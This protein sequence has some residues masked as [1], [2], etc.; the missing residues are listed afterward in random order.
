MQVVR[1][2]HALR[3][4]IDVCRRT[5]ATVGFVPTMGAL[6]EG[7]LSLVR[8]AREASKC[9]VVSIFVNPL[10]FGP[11]ED[12]ERYPRD[13]EGDLALL[14]KEGVDF[15][16]LP[17][18]EELY[19]PGFETKVVPG[20]VA[21][22]LEGAFRPGHFSGVCTVV[23]KLFNLVA[24]HRAWF[25]AKD[26]Q[27]LAV[28][29]RMVRDLSLPIRIE[30]GPTVREADG[31]ALSSRNRYLAPEERAEALSL[32]R[33][34]FAARKLHGAGERSGRVLLDRARRE[35]GAGVVLDYLEIRDPHT[36]RPVPDPVENGLLLVAARVGS[37]R[38][39]DNVPLGKE[40]ARAMGEEG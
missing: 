5:G 39:I 28:I 37:T 38:L 29:R 8:A 14:E 15:A 26:A 23:L 17:R 33:A 6:H 16:F 36:F 21:R 22:D 31:L 40:A 2:G 20:S 12:L 10:Q 35:L 25:G 7:H 27:Q 32:S 1:D 11:G 34:L 18:A 13:E 9:A 19:P 30:V 4:R 3:G 24:P